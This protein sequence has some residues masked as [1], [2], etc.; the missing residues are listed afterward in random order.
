MGVK[1]GPNLHLALD[2]LPS[3]GLAQQSE[4]PLSGNVSRRDQITTCNV[5]VKGDSVSGKNWTGLP[6]GPFELGSSAIL[7]LCHM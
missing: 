4:L 1:F 3:S 2:A 5:V 6:L 7:G